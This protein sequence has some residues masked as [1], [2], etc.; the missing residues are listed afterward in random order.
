MNMK[1]IDDIRRGDDEAEE[2]FVQIVKLLEKLCEQF[3]QG[4]Y[5]SAVLIGTLL[6]TL[7]K[8][9]Q[10]KRR[11][12][13]SVSLLSQVGKKDI[14]FLDTSIKGPSGGSFWTFN[15]IHNCNI[16][17]NQFIYAGLL[18]KTMTQNESDEFSLDFLPLLDRNNNGLRYLNFANWYE[19]TTVFENSSFT[20]TRKDV[21]ET[22]TDKD[23]GAHFDPTIP[24]E[25][26]AFRKP[27]SLN[28]KINGQDAVFK[29]N[30]VYVTLRQIAYEL[31]HSLKNAN[32]NNK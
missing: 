26:A 7:L 4:L 23:G 29:Q 6:R 31:L 28:I 5:Y 1:K 18:Q 15:N 9:S 13:S 21:I 2:A 19:N 17:F 25:Y 32:D 10:D 3:D 14:Q 27:T 20:L 16:Q 8:D 11:K 12:N 30:P 24:E 22:V